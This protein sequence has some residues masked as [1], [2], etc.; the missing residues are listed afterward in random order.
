MLSGCELLGK[1]FLNYFLIFFFRGVANFLT[2]FDKVL[3]CHKTKSS[4]P[5]E[6]HELLGKEGSL[7]SS[8]Q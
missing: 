7:H 2:A 1:K 8:S 5:F 6:I 3:K 4:L